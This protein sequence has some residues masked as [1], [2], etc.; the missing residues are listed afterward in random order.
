MPEGEAMMIDTPSRTF[1]G[2]IRSSSARVLSQAPAPGK[3]F[4]RAPLIVEWE[5]TRACALV[6]RHCRH[7]PITDR[8]GAELSTDEAK[9]LLEDVRAFSTPP[10]AVLMT[11][12][13]ILERPDLTELVAHGSALGIPITVHLCPTGNVTRSTVEALARAGARAVSLGLD[14]ADPAV[15]DTE[16]DDP[17]GF[18]RTTAAASWVREY[19]LEL[20]ILTRVTETT[21]MGLE[22]LAPLVIELG[23]AEWALEFPLP[24]PGNPA[25][26]GINAWQYGV[27]MRWLD[28]LALEAP[29]TITTINGPQWN[30]LVYERL[31]DQGV[32]LADLRRHPAAVRL[33][34]RDGR[35][36][37]FVTRSGDVQPSRHLKIPAG[38]VRTRPLYQIYRRAPVFTVLRDEGRLRG[39]C[40]LCPFRAVCGGSRARAYAA[41]G[42]PL[43]PDPWCLFSP[44]RTS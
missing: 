28:K 31:R 40:G 34:M 17:G 12:G 16:R 33:G 5:L 19:G 10:P 4:A 29:F 3:R 2:P 11:G 7:Q 32:A 20:R 25:V 18:E 24:V 27:V 8:H 9:G 22:A 39:K 13:D 23:A 35:G 15:H 44:W 26:R 38:N 42:D 36:M 41:T 6:C 14:A 1:T 37:L 21:M 43:G 30:R